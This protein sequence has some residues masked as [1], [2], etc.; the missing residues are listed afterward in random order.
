MP[1]LQGPRFAQ[2]LGFTVV[3]AFFLTCFLITWLLPSDSTVKSLI[4]FHWH[5]TS[6]Y[7]STPLNEQ[8]WI[9]DADQ[10][11][12]NFH[13]DVG[14][15]IKT[16]YGTQ[17]RVLPQMEAMGLDGTRNAVVVVGNFNGTLEGNGIKVEVIDVIEKLLSEPWVGAMKETPRAERYYEMHDAIADGNDEKAKAIA[18]ESGWDLDVL[19]VLLLIF[20][21]VD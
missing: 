11:P 8:K 7:F 17:D 12:V 16:G 6:G 15:L 19:K 2:R 18:H 20:K 9:F 14:L 21:L 1:L 4:R 10:Y 5:R 3:V 13:N